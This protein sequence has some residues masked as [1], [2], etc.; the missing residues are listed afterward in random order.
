VFLYDCGMLSLKIR[1]QKMKTLTLNR[2]LTL[3]HRVGFCIKK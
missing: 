1:E 2:V 3:A